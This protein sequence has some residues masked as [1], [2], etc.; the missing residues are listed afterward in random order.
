M[1]KDI[2]WQNFGDGNFLDYGGVAIAKE[3]EN[4]YI[5]CLVYANGEDDEE[6]YAGWTRIDME[7][8]DINSYIDDNFDTECYGDPDKMTDEEK[9]AYVMLDVYGLSAFLEFCMSAF[10]QY[11]YYAGYSDGSA[12]LTN[13]QEVKEG[14]K[15]FGFDT[16]NLNL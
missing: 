9:I 15:S 1:R 2:K 3:D 12:F 7:F 10:N 4:N 13:K 6:I 16:S 11:G 5:V 8:N 14:I